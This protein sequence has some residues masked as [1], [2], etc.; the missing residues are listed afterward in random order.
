VLNLRILNKSSRFSIVSPTRVSE[1]PALSFELERSWRRL[2]LEPELVEALPKMQ[3]I[4]RSSVNAFEP[5][6]RAIEF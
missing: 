2:I 6:A 3:I 1:L 5:F 4:D